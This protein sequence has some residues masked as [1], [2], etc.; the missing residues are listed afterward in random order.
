MELLSNTNDI[1]ISLLGLAPAILAAGIV[2]FA[3]RHKE[4]V[5][6]FL[7]CLSNRTYAMVV[8]ATVVVMTGVCYFVHF[9]V[10]PFG[11]SDRYFVRA[12]NIVEN[13]VFGSGA[14]PTA[15][16]PP[17]YSL[18]LVPTAAILGNIRWAFFLTNITLL[19]GVSI[20]VRFLLQRL[21][22]A[23]RLANFASL[24]VLLYPNRLLSTLI[25]ASDIPFSL[26][27]LCAFLF[28][29]LSV[30]YPERWHYPLITGLIAGIASLIRANGL[31]LMIPLGVGLWCSHPAPRPVRARNVGLLLASMLFILTP[32]T[33]RNALL[34]GKF[35]P[36][37]NNLGMNL[38]IGNNP[39]NQITYNV[40][41]DSLWADPNAGRPPGRES[42]NE[43]ELD[44]YYTDLG[45]RYIREH[46][47]QFVELG[48]QKV[49][50]TVASDASTFGMLET[51]T[52]LRTL[53]FSVFPHLPPHSQTLGAV[54][55]VY[56]VGYL[57]LFIL[58]NAAY[59]SSIML[60]ILVLFRHRRRFTGPEWAYMVAVGI[61]CTLVFVLFGISRYKEP[62]PL[63]TLLITCV[64]VFHPRNPSHVP[65]SR[66]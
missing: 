44:S 55:S 54:F 41:V 18:F 39:S 45:I 49:L 19:V 53:V 61:T 25:P 13:G 60:V 51:Y 32:W 42:W 31:P 37:S 30:T 22:I 11:D 65:G 34:F 62:M 8:P 36:V 35:A 7:Y 47:F 9:K 52:N 46:P 66:S 28:M 20:G 40:Y 50:H 17:G 57:M 10:N 5:I 3:F 2:L 6:T 38:V 12:L 21:G 4:Q 27:Y 58:N 29:T 15:W 63:L 48:F 26:A 33:I 16:Y 56:S 59:Y 24:L 1:L 23:C 14:A 64:A 43:G